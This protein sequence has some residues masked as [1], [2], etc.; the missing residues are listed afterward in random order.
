[1]NILYPYNIRNA[2]VVSAQSNTTDNYTDFSNHKSF[3]ISIKQVATVSL[4]FLSMITGEVFAEDKRL[5]SKASAGR[6]KEAT[7]ETISLSSSLP[8][9]ILQFPLPDLIPS[10]PPVP[11]APPMPDIV[12]PDVVP[13][14]PTMPSPASLPMPDLDNII[15]HKTG[16]MQAMKDIIKGNFK[17]NKVK[18]KPEQGVLKL[19]V[20]L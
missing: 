11:S 1:M 12:P 10:N 20:S 9:V 14:P 7:F 17:L 13:N 18:K 8:D 16:F 3:R 5:K 19:K 4:I 15:K 6:K 2:V